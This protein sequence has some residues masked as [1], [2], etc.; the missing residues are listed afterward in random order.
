MKSVKG[1]LECPVLNRAAFVVR[2]GCNLVFLCVGLVRLSKKARVKDT[3]WTLCSDQFS[4]QLRVDRRLVE[5][6]LGEGE[7]ESKCRAF[8]LSRQP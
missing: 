5:A 3:S 8:S 2:L 6:I 7:Q 1:L 4:G